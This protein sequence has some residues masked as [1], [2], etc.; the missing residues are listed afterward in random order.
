LC[1]TADMR[2]HPDNAY[3]PQRLRDFWPIY[4]RQTGC[5]QGG[6]L[7]QRRRE[8]AKYLELTGKLYRAGV[9][10]LCGT[11]A[12][13]PQVTPGFSLHQELE[14]LVESGL[15]PA[16]ALRAATLNNATALRVDD[17]LGSIAAGKTADIV[18]VTAD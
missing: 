15:P 9:P 3:V 16:A 10:W 13:E 12:P 18:L 17:Q 4:L 2:D 7:E 8:M 11:D 6:L 5:P 1:D 14:L